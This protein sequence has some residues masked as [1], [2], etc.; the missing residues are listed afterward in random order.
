MSS[1]QERDKEL[2]DLKADLDALK[3]E[4][5]AYKDEKQKEE[6]RKLRTALI[7]AGGIILT[8]GGFVWAEIIWPVISSGRL[9]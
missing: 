4:F 5:Q 6:S 3:R 7:A 9:K 1:D 8:M 2:S